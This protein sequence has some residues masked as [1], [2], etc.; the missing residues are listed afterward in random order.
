MRDIHFSDPSTRPH[1]LAMLASRI[2]GAFR[3]QP[4]QR[5]QL[6][7]ASY[8]VEVYLVKDVKKLGRAGKRA[9]VVDGVIRSPRLAD[10]PYSTSTDTHL[11]DNS[12]F[13]HGC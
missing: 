5:Q 13:R 9:H 7:H 1:V 8:T 3:T 2:C 11:T 4:Q 6:R 12:P 10:S